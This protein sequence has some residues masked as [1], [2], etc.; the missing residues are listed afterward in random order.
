MNIKRK[1]I[2]MLMILFL[3]GGLAALPAQAGVIDGNAGRTREPIEL[4]QFVRPGQTTIIDF[5]SRSCQPCMKLAPMLDS[6]AS[7]RPK[8]QVVK[9]NIDRPGSSGIDFDSPLAKQYNIQGIP[10]LMVYDESG[11]LKAQGQSAL[12]M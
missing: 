1:T 6:M 9:L 10:Y 7:R 8:T 11:M 3:L 5:Y 2:G 4:K 12:N